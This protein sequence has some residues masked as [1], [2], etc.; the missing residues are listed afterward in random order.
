MKLLEPN[1]K[2]HQ[3]YV[4]NNFMDITAQLGSLGL[5]CIISICQ[6]KCMFLSMASTLPALFGNN[7]PVFSCPCSACGRGWTAVSGLAFKVSLGLEEGW[8]QY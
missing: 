1:I 2:W 7:D 3:G 8:K 6:L 4:E 5:R